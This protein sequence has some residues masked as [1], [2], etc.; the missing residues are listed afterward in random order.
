MSA[1]ADILRPQGEIFF[2]H[3]IFKENEQQ[4]GNDKVVRV[5]AVE[6]KEREVAYVHPF[7]VSA[8]CTV[9]S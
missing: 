2:N 7:L 9:E 4:E 3:E 8:L 1:Y 5:H 6:R